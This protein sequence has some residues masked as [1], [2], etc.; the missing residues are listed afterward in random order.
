MEHLDSWFMSYGVLKIPTKV[1]AC[2]QPLSMQQ[3]LPRLPISRGGKE[4]RAACERRVERVRPRDPIIATI[5]LPS[6]WPMGQ[7]GCTI[8][9]H[10]HMTASTL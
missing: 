6:H 4:R 9:H 1:W 5:Q 2:S 7:L 8:P 3:Y 10:V